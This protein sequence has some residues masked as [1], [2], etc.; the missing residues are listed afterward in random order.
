MKKLLVTLLMLVT[1][2]SSHAIVG[3]YQTYADFKSG[4][5]ITFDGGDYKTAGKFLEK[6]ISGKVKG[7]TKTFMLKDIYGINLNNELYR[8]FNYGG[9]VVTAK[10]YT[11]ADYQLY[12]HTFTFDNAANAGQGRSATIYYVSKGLDGDMY[13]LS[14]MKALEEVSDA[15]PEYKDLVKACA[16]YK[17][18]AAGR[19]SHV[20]Y[21]SPN[22]KLG[23]DIMPPVK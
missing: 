8:I 3:V 11:T 23:K 12:M 20:I 4:N 18:D 13:R 16:K 22:Y 17:L 21:A 5:L 14:T 9:A 7:E 1:F 19:V 6:T 2:F 15:H 10:L